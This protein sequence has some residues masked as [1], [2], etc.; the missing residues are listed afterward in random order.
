MMFRTISVFVSLLLATLSA[1]SHAQSASAKGGTQTSQE[2]N[3]ILPDS[4]DL[5]QDSEL[6]NEV[7]VTARKP[8]VQ[9]QADKVTYN[10]DEDP[11][12]QTANVL[13]AIRKVPMVSVDAEGNIK[14]KG[15]SDFKIY[16]NGKPDPSISSNYKDIL[17][18][19]P[20][21]S[22]KKI[23]VLT[24]PGAKY[25]AEGV[26]GIINIVTVSATKLEGYSATLS[27]SGNNRQIGGNVSATAKI[28]KVSMNLNYSHNKV[29]SSDFATEMSVEY[30][31]N[32]KDH[33]YSTNQKSKLKN[34]FDFG[35]IQMSWEPD[36]INLFTLNANMMQYGFPVNTLLHYAMTDIDGKDQW[37]YSSKTNVKQNNYNYT[38]GANWQHNFKT[39]EHNIV[40]LYQY[41]YDKNVRDQSNIYTDYWNYPGT[42]P[43]NMSLT[44]YP[45]H[46]HTFQLDY[47]L[48]FL[49]KNVLEVGAKYIMR[50]NYGDTR[51]FIR[52]ADSDEW[53]LNTDN[54]IDMTQHQDVSSI[55]AAY[56]GHFA[57]LIVKGG[58][59]GKGARV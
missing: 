11:T 1:V 48:P 39:P 16:L 13:D 7:V 52:S 33:L 56:T 25:D 23:E 54:S 2:S 57:N 18:G 17:R 14:L 46:E 26:G 6:L 45:N 9:T 29:L 10:M 8:L 24:E 3:V 4:L 59:R 21:S 5:D 32:P 34:R 58:V 15:Q 28:G 22:I 20:A 19:M 41:N 12:A 37:K 47:T 35:G 51:Q 55:Y 44:R 38:V 42:V 43:D 40:L 30:L 49:K 36:T 50:R 27:L 31:N 53:I